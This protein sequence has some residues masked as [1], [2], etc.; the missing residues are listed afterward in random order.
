MPPR[1]KAAKANGPGKSTKGSAAAQRT[2]GKRSTT[3][4]ANTVDPAALDNAKA[5]ADGEEAD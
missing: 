5:L 4:R 1:K 3:G 2:A